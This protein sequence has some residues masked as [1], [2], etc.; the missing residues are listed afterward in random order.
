MLLTTS[1]GTLW[2]SVLATWRESLAS[3]DLALSRF[4]SVFNPFTTETQNGGHII[5]VNISFTASDCDQSGA[6]M[7]S[8]AVRVMQQLSLTLIDLVPD[9]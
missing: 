1:T 7:L 5:T 9:R 4:Y 8:R 6:R 3:W 2:Q